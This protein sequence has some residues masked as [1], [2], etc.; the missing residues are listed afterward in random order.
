MIFNF[1]VPF[2]ITIPPFV[3]HHFLEFAYLICVETEEKIKKSSVFETFGL[4]SQSARRLWLAAPSSPSPSLPLYNSNDFSELGLIPDHK[5]KT[6]LAKMLFVMWV[7]LPVVL[8]V[9]LFVAMLVMLFVVLLVVGLVKRL[10]KP[11]RFC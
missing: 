7:V 1:S 2:F 9:V 5:N 10:L 8:P 6:P 11:L 4:L 3:T